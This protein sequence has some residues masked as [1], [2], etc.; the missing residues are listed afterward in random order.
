MDAGDQSAQIAIIVEHLHPRVVYTLET[1]LGEFLGLRPRLIVWDD[2]E[3][4]AAPG[5]L[6]T[7]NYRPHP[8][9]IYPNLPCN[10][11]LYEDI[12]RQANEQIDWFGAVSDQLRTADH[13]ARIFYHLTQYELLRPAGRMELDHHG[14][15]PDAT[16][17][18]FIHDWL[19]EIVALIQPWLPATIPQRAFDFEITIDVDQPWKY[20]HKPWWVRW[21]GLL[22]DVSQH[23]DVGTRW[24]VLTGQQPDPFEVLDVVKAMCPAAQTKVFFLVGGNHPHDS[25]YDIR[26]KPYQ[27]LVRDWQ[28]AG[29]EIGVHPSYETWTNPA[30]MQTEKE[31]LEQVVG[32]VQISRQH[33]LRY[34]TPQT[35]RQLVD[36]GI[37]RDY[38]L[39]RSTRPGPPTGVA[40]PYRWFDLQ[41][42]AATSLQLVPSMVMDRGLLHQ[43]LQPHEAMRAIRKAIAQTQAVGGHFVIILH[44]ET[45]SD[46]G[47]WLGWQAVIH[48]MLQV[49]QS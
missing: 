38:T 9:S 14:R 31:G 15:Y 16:G 45:F 36:L 37:Q 26:Q 4:I 40:L 1:V 49:L 48:D 25:R 11:L 2:A 47:E 42:N 46:V 6:P 24:K 17:P 30:M 39:C 32:P 8:S 19:Q 12:I 21:G 33:Y 18:L 34:K 7:L 13:L 44:N 43:G 28:A 10:G 35:F 41:R 23:G 5:T 29:F 27:Q 22:K 20:L 3:A